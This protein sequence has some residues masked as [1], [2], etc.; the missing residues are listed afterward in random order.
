MHY[1]LYNDNTR[2][3]ASSLTNTTLNFF[4]SIYNSTYMYTQ[5][6]T[7]TYIY[8]RIQTLHADT[9]TRTYSR[10][11]THAHTRTHTHTPWLYGNEAVAS[12]CHQP[13]WRIRRICCPPAWWE[14]LQRLPWLWLLP[15]PRRPG[16]HVPWWPWSLGRWVWGRRK[17]VGSTPRTPGWRRGLWREVGV[18]WLSTGVTWWHWITRLSRGQGPTYRELVN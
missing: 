3:L 17:T 16:S 9:H 13:A 7:L 2:D 8:A 10:T 5:S 11:P 6:L 4:S 1:I 14:C 15:L 18:S 12:N